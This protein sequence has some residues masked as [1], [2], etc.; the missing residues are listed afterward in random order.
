MGWKDFNTGTCG[1][2][3]A[4]TRYGRIGTGLVVEGRMDNGGWVFACGDWAL[5]I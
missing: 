2:W 4:G 5:G 1:S 3:S